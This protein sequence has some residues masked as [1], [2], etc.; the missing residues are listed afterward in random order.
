MNAVIDEDLHRSFA[1]V[2]VGLGFKVFDVR[3]CGLRGFSDDAILEFTLEKHAVL[4]TADIGFVNRVAVMESS[5]YGVVLLRYPNEL[6]T[7]T[8]NRDVA[9]LFSKLSL[10]DFTRN[11]LVVSPGQLRIRRNA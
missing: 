8:V 2:L 9:A 11:I 6:S 1:S 7:A 10:S 4:F 3:D 5:H